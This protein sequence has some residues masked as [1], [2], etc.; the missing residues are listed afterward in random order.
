MDILPVHVRACVFILAAYGLG[1]LYILFFY[2]Y[3]YLIKWSACWAIVTSAAFLSGHII[4]FIIAVICI[5]IFLIPKKLSE[6]IKYYFVLLP[7]IPL[8]VYEVSGPLGINLV[9]ELNYARLL[10]LVIIV[11]AFIAIIRKNGGFNKNFLNSLLDK[12]I[13]VYV[14]L[15]CVLSFRN[16]TITSGF[17][18]SFHLIFL[19]IFLPY[20]VISRSIQ[21][22]NDF[23]RVFSGILF[24]AVMLSFLGLF[25]Q[26]L[27]WPF[28]SY[29]PHL[30]DFRPVLIN[31]FGEVRG[32]FL[33]INATMAPIPLGY[34]MVFAISVLLFMKDLLPKR[35]FFFLATFL[36]FSITL[37]FTGS[38]GAWLTAIVFLTW[39]A[40]LRI[41]DFWLKLSLLTGGAGLIFVGNL[42]LSMMGGLSTDSLDEHGTFQ[43][44][45]DL[46][47]TSVDVISNNLLFG[48]DDPNRGGA[49]ESMRQG[50]G[51]IDIVNSYLELLFFQGVI[52]FAL[53]LSIFGI[54]LRNL[55]ATVRSLKRNSTIRSLGNTLIAMTIATLV[56][57]GTVSSVNFIPIYYWSLIGLA[58]AY[59][60]MCKSYQ[61]RQY[62]GFQK[63]INGLD[64]IHSEVIPTNCRY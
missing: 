6:Q 29:L 49:L 2:R 17:R 48:T 51:I 42:V 64:S 44:R 57:I 47:I 18:E 62:R 3:K 52:G 61:V 21:T 19:N 43:Y 7:A 55:Y 8:F 13:F 46:I 14:L 45:V 16:T 5:K 58:S 32:T 59:V 4:I 50:Q 15:L 36:L 33:R 37:V 53:F 31:S 34:F 41:T 25:E 11:P 22:L 39:Y 27:H 30:L 26:K 35:R 20:Y 1:T 40:Y 56:M 23:R 60:R 10:S 24:S 54:V 63:I 12:L 38:R 28:F 9:L